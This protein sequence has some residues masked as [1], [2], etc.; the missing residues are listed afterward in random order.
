[1]ATGVKSFSGSIGECAYIAG[2][3]PSVALDAHSSV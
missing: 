3:M 2:L 1:M